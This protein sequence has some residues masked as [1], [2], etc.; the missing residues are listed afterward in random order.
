MSR[1]GLTILFVAM[2]AGRL[3]VD[4]AP[5][6][7]A[8]WAGVVV[9][10]EAAEYIGKWIRKA[11]GS[12]V[13]RTYRH[14]DRGDTSP[15]SARFTPKLIEAGLYEVRLLYP[16]HDNRATN[17]SVS[18]F[19]EE[20]EAR[21]I[22]N[23]RD[24]PLVSGV[25]RS[26]GVFRFA[27]GRQGSVVVS[28]S[29]ADGFVVVDAVQFVPEAIARAERAAAAHLLAEPKRVRHTAASPA[30]L[31]LEWD[32]VA[33]DETGYRI[34]RREAGGAVFPGVV[35]AKPDGAWYLA[36]ETGPGAT[37]FDDGGM[38]QRTSYEHRVAAFND[39][40]EGPAAMTAAA[41]ATLAMQTHL[42][43]QIVFPDDGVNL[44]KS[45]SAVELKS[46]EL[47]LAY[48]LADVATRKSHHDESLWLTTSRDGRRGWSEPRPLLRGDKKV[49]F[50]KP[51]LVRRGDGRLGL[52]FS[53]W[54]CDEAGKIT[55]RSRQFLVSADEGATWTEPVDI[56]P[57]S[58]NN[59]TLIVGKNGRLLESLSDTT[60]V[61]HVYASDDH[62]RSWRPL[63][64]VPGKR[65]GE[66]ALAHVGDGRLV[67]LSRHEWPFYRLSFSA[68]NGDT[69]KS[70][71]SLLYLGGGDN[72]PKLVVLPDGKTLA[73]VVHSWYP[74][75]KAK[76]RRQLA[77]VIS[78]DGGRTWDNFRLIG[79][80]PAGD[81]GFLQHSLTFVGETAYLFYGGGSRLDTNDGKDLRLI[82][83]SQ[84]F[85]TSTTPW[86][87]DWQGRPLARR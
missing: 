50:G 48:D 87:Y 69:W 73:A 41:T 68:D 31:R 20:G 25:P 58:A 35:A 40:G 13:G 11:K 5:V 45:P 32:D 70:Q 6:A 55:G 2:I 59:H 52:S 44:T 76:D 78:R 17:A 49:I 67:Y 43:P 14:D 27:A 15:K 63:S 30:H 7:P 53:R 82:R 24:N 47:L 51:A 46:G 36:G 1:R 54:T 56:G 28:A 62:G 37:H 71:E 22:A 65:L 10:D 77:S 38:Q 57:M 18:V 83:L 34:W 79:F 75:K 12:F 19:S 66:A 86:P 21:R 61:N 85:F 8:S 72:P 4:A 33:T 23:L 26:L 84:E 81:D 42:E 3:H 80:A 60:G 9:D 39:S 16:A 74:G 64:L 29:D